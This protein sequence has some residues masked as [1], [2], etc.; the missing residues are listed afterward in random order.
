MPCRI[1]TLDFAGA[2]ATVCFCSTEPRQPC[3]T[4]GAPAPFLCDWPDPEKPSQ[5]TAADVRQ[6][7]ILEVPVARS[8][9]V[10]L[11]VIEVEAVAGR[12]FRFRGY[13]RSVG[14]AAAVGWASPWMLAEDVVTVRRPGTCDAP[15]C[16]QHAREVGEDRHYCAGCWGRW[17]EIS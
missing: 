12:S 11:P 14:V 3:A 2:T 10:R 1:E 9:R 5:V 16:E 15:C 8:K 6:G 7:D 13:Y 17:G 4:C